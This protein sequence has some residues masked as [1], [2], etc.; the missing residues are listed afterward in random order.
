MVNTLRV[1]DALLRKETR[2]GPVWHRYNEDGYGEHEDGTP[3]DSTGIGRG[4]PL[5]AGERAH[6]ELAAG[7]VDEARRLGQ[8]MRAQSSEAGLI[9]EQVWDAAD[10]PELDLFNGR[11]SGSARPL[12]WA[13]AEYVKLVR[14][15]QDGRVFDTPPQA[16]TRYAHAA[17][18]ARM[19][20]WAP[21]NKRRSISTGQVLRIQTL[22]PVSVHWSADDWRTVRD[23]QATEVD[24]GVWHA[25][26][27]TDAL[28][29]TDVIRFTLF[30]REEQ[31]WQE[32]D[33]AITVTDAP[34]R[35][36]D[37]MVDHAASARQVEEAGA[38]A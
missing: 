12:V 10:I 21:N 1:I 34:L 24:L 20:Y 32:E 6:Y 28:P 2:T 13:H 11:A 7:R 31:R 29:P 35:S 30:W 22:A 27:A 38:T 23:D 19:A 17:A 36:T 4:W 37:A 25:D 5:L 3:F 15:L 16:V 33:Y 14:S 9:P 8:V 26:L 18:P